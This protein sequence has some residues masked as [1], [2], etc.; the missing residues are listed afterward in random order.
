MLFP[1]RV[2]PMQQVLGAGT[3]QMSATVLHDHLAID[4]ARALRDQEACEIGKFPMFP[5]PAERDA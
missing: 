1:S 5:A 2:G 3:A 4:V